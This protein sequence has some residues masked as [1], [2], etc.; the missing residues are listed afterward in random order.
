[1]SRR[2]ESGLGRRAFVLSGLGIL[3]AGGGAAVVR[4]LFHAAT[5]SYDGTQYKGEIVQADYA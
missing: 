3:I 5:F 1:M 4:K 2:M